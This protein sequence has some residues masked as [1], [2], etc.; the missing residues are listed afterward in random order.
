MENLELHKQK[1]K[2]SFKEKVSLWGLSREEEDFLDKKGFLVRDLLTLDVLIRN[3]PFQLILLAIFSGIWFL[4][5]MVLIIAWSELSNILLYSMMATITPLF[6]YF[7]YKSL[8]RYIFLWKGFIKDSWEIIYAY[9]WNLS[10]N[11]EK[12]IQ[13]LIIKIQKSSILMRSMISS[14]KNKDIIWMPILAII[15]FANIFWNQQINE[16][17]WVDLFFWYTIPVIF[18]LFWL[19]IFSFIF[20]QLVE[21]FHP[22]YAFGNL[23]EKIQKLTPQIEEQSQKIQSEFQSDMNFS[24]LSNWFDSLSATFSEIVSLVIKLEKVEARA[25]KWN[26]FDSEKYINSLRSDIII[27]LT[28]LKTFLEK[29]KIELLE[30]QKELTRVRVWG[31]EST[32]NIELQSKRSE[33]LIA[34]LTE[35]IEKLDV[36][37]G[38]MG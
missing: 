3:I 4:I 35:N 30:S 37:I 28:S 1:K 19:Y 9:G 22:L 6:I 21:H 11:Q 8:L 10:W 5:W 31:D 2:L 18:T 16:I 24:V 32:G 17:L 7:I 25:N 27:P 26:L 33:S 38:K 36:M 12:W 13:N 14:T 29:Q 34:E 15:I 20:R 23:G